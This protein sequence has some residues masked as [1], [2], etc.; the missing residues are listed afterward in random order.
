MYRTTATLSSLTSTVIRC[1]GCKKFKTK[2]QRLFFARADMNTLDHCS[3]PF[4]VCRSKKAK[5]AI[6]V[7]H[8]FDSTLPPYLSCTLLLGLSVPVQMKNIFLVQDRNLWAFVTG[9]SL[10][11]LPSSGTTFLLTSNATVLSPSS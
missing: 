5:I 10:F 11:R 4:S 6:F 8:F 9:H 1:I 2:K 7:F 3:K